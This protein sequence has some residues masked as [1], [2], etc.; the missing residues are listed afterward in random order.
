MAAAW[1]KPDSAS[2]PAVSA[3]QAGRDNRP[4]AD[5]VTFQGG[6][7]SPCSS[8]DLKMMLSIALEERERFMSGT[9]TQAAKS[10]SHV[11]ANGVR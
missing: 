6:S 10:V 11:C 1:D 4:A 7:A 9:D 2:L 3:G 5:V 8:L